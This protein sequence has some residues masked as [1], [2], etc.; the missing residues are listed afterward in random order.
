MADLP[1]FLDNRE[2]YVFGDFAFTNL[3]CYDGTL[4]FAFMCLVNY[5]A[6]KMYQDGAFEL[7]RKVGLPVEPR[8]EDILDG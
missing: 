3:F 4:A 6:R 5:P 8:T 1:E 2:G 7:G